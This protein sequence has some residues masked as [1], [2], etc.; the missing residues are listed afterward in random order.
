MMWLTELSEC[1]Q[2]V[3][4]NFSLLVLC[5]LQLMWF[6]IMFFLRLSS[7]LQA[8]QNS[9]P[10]LETVKHSSGNSFTLCLG[11]TDF[12]SLDPCPLDVFFPVGGLQSIFLFLVSS[13]AWGALRT[14][15]NDL[16]L[17]A[18]SS[19]KWLEHLDLSDHNR[20][21]VKPHGTLNFYLEHIVRMRSIFLCSWG[22]YYSS[23][24]RSCLLFRKL[25]PNN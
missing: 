7:S 13:E 25:F 22:A 3:L 8:L 24:V 2:C 15:N 12:G 23:F 14:S 19:I 16:G 1:S 4:L 20:N 17:V 9:F 5:F 6:V 18:V 11:V 21:N 10:P